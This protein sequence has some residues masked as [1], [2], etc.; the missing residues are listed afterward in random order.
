M[1]GCKD[2]RRHISMALYASTELYRISYMDHS[3][4]NHRSV[5]LVF[6]DFDQTLYSACVYVVY[7]AVFDNSDWFKSYS[8]MKN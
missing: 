4:S 7:K 6:S 5:V 2:S 1:L 8:G 3:M